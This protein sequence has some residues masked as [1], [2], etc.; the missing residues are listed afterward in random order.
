MEVSFPNQRF[1][2]RL[3]KWECLYWLS[4]REKE[5][6]FALAHGFGPLFLGIFTIVVLGDVIGEVCLSHT[7]QESKQERRR[8][9]DPNTFLKVTLLLTLRLFQSSLSISSTIDPQCHRPGSST[10]VFGIVNYSK[11]STVLMRGPWKAVWS[12]V[13]ICWWV[14][15]CMED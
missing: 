14:H 13:T 10:W 9:W 8:G 12:L 15:I 11:T 4:T 2:Q 1:L 7:V 6:N 5:E 3:F